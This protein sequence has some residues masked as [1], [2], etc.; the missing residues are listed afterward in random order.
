MQLRITVSHIRKYAFHTTIINS[1]T[2]FINNANARRY[3]IVRWLK[4]LKTDCGLRTEKFMV[5]CSV[6]ES[7][8]I[9]KAFPGSSIYYCH[10]HVGQLWEKRLKQNTTVR[11][12]SALLPL[13]TKEQWCVIYA[14]IHLR[15]NRPTR[16]DLYWTKSALRALLRTCRYTGSRS[17]PS[18]RVPPLSSI[19]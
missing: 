3:I 7:A 5:D 14:H 18:I 4:W 9:V 2:I 10:F 6:T 19:I 8:A 1:N 16:C 12:Q 15:P 11:I 17:K 13:A